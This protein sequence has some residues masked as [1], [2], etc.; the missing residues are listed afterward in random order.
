MSTSSHVSFIKVLTVYR[1]PLFWLCLLRVCCGLWSS[2][3]AQL[4]CRCVI[5]LFALC[6]GIP[7]QV[8]QVCHDTDCVTVDCF[9]LSS[10]LPELKH[11]WS[12]GRYEEALRGTGW[13]R[14]RGWFRD[15][16]DKCTTVSQVPLCPCAVLGCTCP[17]TSVLASCLERS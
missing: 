1:T 10:M 12:N 5:V 4:P 15:A 2:S 14:R 9:R 6:P 17:A 8:M 16:L 3:P 11:R 7:C 13:G